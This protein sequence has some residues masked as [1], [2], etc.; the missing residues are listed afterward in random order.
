MADSH[1][2]EGPLAEFVALRQEIESR[3]NRQQQFQTLQLTATAGI[4]GLALT[5]RELAGLLL[6]LPL[7]SYALCGR[8]VAQQYGIAKCGTYIHDELS[9]RV[10][11]GFGWERWLRKLPSDQ[12]VNWTMPM[13]VTFPGVSA[14]A[15]IWTTAVVFG[16]TALP[17]P[18]RWLLTALWVVDLG[19][20]LAST[21]LIIRVTRNQPWEFPGSSTLSNG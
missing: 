1:G 4:F 5:G 11:G 21:Y 6:T 17:F 15:L 19:C 8:V 9:Q 14:I 16:R 20:T 10:P 7:I 12:S 13:V 18:G 2:H 3:S